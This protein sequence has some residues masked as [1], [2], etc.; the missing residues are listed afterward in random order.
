VAALEEAGF[1]VRS[2]AGFGLVQSEMNL[3]PDLILMD[4]NLPG[5]SG[6]QLGEILRSQGVP[7]VIFSSA[8]P[9]RLE[10]ARACIGAVAA[11]SKGVPLPEIAA[12]IRGHLLGRKA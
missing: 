8:P 10:A 9:E 12:W 7:I 3:R 11:F 2:V 4:L 5:L 6:E 1:D